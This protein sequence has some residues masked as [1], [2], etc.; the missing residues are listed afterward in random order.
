[1][2]LAGFSAFL[3]LYATQS[4]LPFLAR[5]FAASPLAVSATVGATTIAV[6]LAAPL[7]G[8]FADRLGR[9]RII[10]GAAALLTLPTALAATAGSLRALVAWRFAQG[11]CMP[12][13]FAVTM[14]YVSEEWEAAGVGRAMAGYVT[15]NVLGGVTGRFL[16]GVVASAFGWRAAFVV[17]AGLN[18]AAAILLGRW[19]AASRR[20]VRAPSVRD[21]LR[22]L[23]SHATNPMVLAA[24]LVGFNVLFSIVAVFTYVAF[25]LAAPPFR[26]G[27]AGLGAIFFV[28]LLG[29]VTTPIAGRWL[30]RV[31]YRAVFAAAAACAAA[32]VLTTLVPHL[33][34]LLGGLAVCAAGTFVCQSAAGSFVGAAAGYARSSA[35]GLYVA[36]YYAGGTAGATLP[37]LAWRSGGWPACVALVVAVQ[38]ATAALALLLWRPAL[39]AQAS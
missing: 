18:L 14:A 39:A 34:I 4:L 6:A 22:A 7:V 28:Y 13:I 33:A 20:F 24:C 25:H 26:L 38:L 15:G 32:G 30:D 35:T 19:L 10:V 27:P 5:T 11:L 2:G 8:L 1:V 12:A 17:L 31:G 16:T 36:C 9:K 21:S 37:G 23:A 3:D 29:A